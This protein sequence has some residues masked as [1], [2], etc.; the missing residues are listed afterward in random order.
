VSYTLT[1]Q[2]RQAYRQQYLDAPTPDYERYADAVRQMMAFPGQQ[3]AVYAVLDNRNGQIQYVSDTTPVLGFRLENLSE[4]T[5]LLALLPPDHADYP[6]LSGNWT[7]NVYQQIPPAQ[8]LNLYG[9]HCGLKLRQTDE[10][11]ARLMLRFHCIDHDEHNNSLVTLI[12]IQDITHLYNGDHYWLRMSFGEGSKTVRHYDSGQQ[13]TYDRDLTS[14]REKEVLHLLRQGLESKTIGERLAISTA[15]VNQHRR[16][17][18][19][20]TGA[21]DTT[22]LLQLAE[23]CNLC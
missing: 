8:K 21:R 3:Q 22:A 23:W 7:L 2:L 12:I 15:T 11:M 19:A 17:M 16:N 1:S 6:A 18:L 5:R 20:R 4:A 10:T 14:D 13:R 9:V